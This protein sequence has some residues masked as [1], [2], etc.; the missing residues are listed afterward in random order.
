MIARS[1]RP[2]TLGL[3]LLRV[4]AARHPTDFAWAGYP[5]AANPSGDDHFAR[6]I[7]HRAVASS[8]LGLDASAAP[9]WT[10][11]WTGVG[12]WGVRVAPVLMY[13]R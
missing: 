3:H 12:D 2:V 7:G 8:L 9:T 13:E 11:R 6:L 5:T 4:I 1:T 10:A